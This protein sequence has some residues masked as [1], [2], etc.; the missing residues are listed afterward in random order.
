MSSEQNN[1]EL[2]QY[3][4]SMIEKTLQAISDNLVQLAALE[5]KH[6]ETREAL[7]RAFEHIDEHEER[8]RGM[9]TEMP[10]LKMVKGWV[11]TGVIGIIGLL[12]T[13][14]FSLF[15]LSVK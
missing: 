2:T 3:R 9:E 11:I 6:I 10:M 12:G 1:D 15:H 4:L 8:I 14:V 5:Q 13:T 7:S